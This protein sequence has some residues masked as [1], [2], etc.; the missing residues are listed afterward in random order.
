[1]K[2]D[3]NRNTETK[4][5]KS[6]TTSVKNRIFS[7]VRTA[8]WLVFAVLCVLYGITVYLVGSGTSFFL[9]W[10]ALAAGFVFLAFAALIGLWKKLPKAVRVGVVAVVALG[11]VF[12]TGVEGLILTGFDEKGEENLDAIIVLGSQVYANGPSVVLRYRLDEAIRY[13][14][15]NPETVCI[16]TGGQGYN[17]PFPEAEG[18]ADYLIKNGI[19]EDRILL[20]PESTNTKENIGNS[21]QFID[22]NDRIGIVTNNYHVFRGVG[23]ARKAGLKNVCGI[24]A[25][26]APRYLPNNMLR[27]FFG[28]VKYF[29]VGDI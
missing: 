14:N 29:L 10:F 25:D 21:L 11:I 7:T 13:L 26:S 15:E 1:M 4:E 12:F 2:E 22:A 6:G 27:E 18:M 19:D 9:V 24:S 23:V 20:E 5:R 8:V 28:V 3:L 16:V 17:E